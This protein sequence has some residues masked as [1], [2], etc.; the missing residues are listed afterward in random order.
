MLL[1]LPTFT[2]SC[3]YCHLFC[4]RSSRRPT[5]DNK[6]QFKVLMGALPLRP[7]SRLPLCSVRKVRLTCLPRGGGEEKWE[8]VCTTTGP[9]GA[10]GERDQEHSWFRCETD[11]DPAE[12]HTNLSPSGTSSFRTFKETVHFTEASEGGWSRQK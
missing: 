9:E 2:L 10:S 12:I 7:R 5:G 3:F 11:T 1:L 8:K 4:P 6:V